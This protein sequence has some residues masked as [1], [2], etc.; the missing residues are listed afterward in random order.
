MRILV[1]GGTGA[2]GEYL[3]QCLKET[4]IEIV[5]TSRTYKS[6]EANICYLQGNAKDTSFLSSLLLER[7]DA[8]VDFMVYST[9]EFQSRFTLLLE[10]T[11]QYIFLSSSRVYAYSKDPISEKS[12]RL[13]DVS[14]DQDFL[15]TDEYAL[16][17]ARQENLLVNSAY[18]NWTIVRPYITYSEKRLQLGSLEKE[19]WL[20]R[21]LKGKAIVFP[22]EMCSKL[23]TLTYSED[24]S[25]GIVALIGNKKAYSEI[26]HIT[27]NIAIPWSSILNV[28]LDV[29]MKKVGFRPKVFF[30]SNQNFVKCKIARYQI[31]YDR[32]FDRKFDNSKISKYVKTELFLTVETGL[33]KCIEEFLLNPT[34]KEI[35]WRSEAIKDRYTKERMS[36]KNVPGLKNKIKYLCFRFSFK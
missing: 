2:I 32:L 20:Y 36:L 31:L 10:A 11:S 12:P 16:A 4:N 1:L 5:V 15:S 13:L 24:V 17:K 21:A 14:V 8:I 25:R 28:Y 19:E 26:F 27:S 7:W 29:I 33:K 35:D 34:F 18:K 23:T 9:N 6:S 3:V 30:V 22:H